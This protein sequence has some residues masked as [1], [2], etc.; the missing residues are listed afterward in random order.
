MEQAVCRKKIRL[1]NRDFS[2]TSYMFMDIIKV[3]VSQI[4]K[5]FFA[6]RR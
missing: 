2:C 1:Y 5:I 6:Q 3:P 4:D